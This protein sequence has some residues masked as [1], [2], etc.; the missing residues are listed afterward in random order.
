M[1]PKPK[2]FG[3]TGGISSGKS[4]VARML[5]SLGAEYIDADEMCHKLLLKK[6]IKNKIIENYGK[7]IQDGSGNIDR[8]QLAAMVFQ[9]KTHL[10]FLCNIL[11]PIVIEQIRSKITTIENQERQKTI[12]IDAALLEESELSLLCDYVI[13]VNTGKE[14]REKRCLLSRH[15]KK[16]EL[17][18]RERFQMSLEE[19]KKRADYIIDNNL[20]EETTF[21]QIEKF[22]KYYKETL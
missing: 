10:D 6:E 12:V 5:A 1:V 19:K 17:E 8:A 13:F 16:G 4:T 20:T 15:W 9:E 11:H 3:I 7:S 22:W 18:K 2:I 21:R 14:T